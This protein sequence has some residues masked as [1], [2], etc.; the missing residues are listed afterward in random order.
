MKIQFY[1]DLLFHRAG[2][3]EVAFNDLGTATPFPARDEQRLFS[4]LVTRADAPAQ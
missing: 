3:A 1:A 2:P 4:L